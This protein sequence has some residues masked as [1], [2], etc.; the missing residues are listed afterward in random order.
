MRRKVGIDNECLDEEEEEEEREEKN[1]EMVL[2]T[3]E[4][5]DNAVTPGKEEIEKS[6]NKGIRFDL[7][8]DKAS[9]SMKRPSF[10]VRLQEANIPNSATI[11]PKFH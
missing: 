4:E 1:S 3:V 11:I 6:R 10:I 5:E 2:E 9:K 7:Q 8:N